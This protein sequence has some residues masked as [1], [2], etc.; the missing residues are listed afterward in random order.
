M[1][2]IFDIE[3]DGLDATKIHCIAVRN[4]ETG[5]S[6]VFSPENLTEGFRLLRCAKNLIGHNIISY[7]LPVIEKLHSMI[8]PAAE[9][10]DTLLLARLC[11]PDV[12]QDDWSRVNDGFPKELVGRHSL[13]AWGYRL[14]I[15]KDD[16][17]E[18]TDWAEYSEEM[19]AYC[20]RDTEVTAALWRA[21]RGEKPTKTA[22]QIEH[23]F[24]KVIRQMEEAGFGFDRKAAEELAQTLTVRREE[25]RSE[26]VAAFPPTIV[27]MKIKTKEI[28]FNPASRMDIARGLKKLH[29]WEP[30]DF[31]PDGRAKIDESVLSSMDYT[32]AKLLLE[33]LMVSKRLG[34][35]AE[36]KE[37][38]LGLEKHGRIHGRVNTNGAVT[39]RC[40]HSK[41]NMAQVPGGRSPYG[42]ECRSLFIP[43]PGWVLVGADA[44]GLELRCLAHYMA[45]YDGG[46]YAK[47]ILE[48]DI[49]TTNQ[50]AAGLDTRDQAKLFIYAFLYGAGDEKVGT[51]IGG[52]SKEGK[53][54]KKQFLER[55]PALKI[56][57]EKVQKAAKERGF[58]VGLDG[59]K[60]PVRSAH[61]ALNTL[62]QSAGAVI[63]KQATII[64][65][66]ELE[67]ANIAWG[68]DW[69][70]VA[71][72][73]DEVQ[74]ECDG[75]VA[76]EVGVTA[77]G[78]IREAGE[79]LG[80]KCRLDGEWRSG[81]SWAETH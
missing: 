60:L 28:P 70:L 58:L 11:W 63:M 1:N 76:S 17:G 68:R 55:T 8:F 27:E 73:H 18:T 42:K 20:L 72:V 62:L 40:T 80:F 14:G 74:I 64:L 66:R 43:K 59:R 81:R 19:A 56:L 21:I 15:R 41:P 24:A 44:S 33:Y 3:T 25:L 47:E 79:S 37:A 22:V 10:Y 51:I 38:W 46:A 35:L 48:G 75:G 32:E 9:V 67:S 53:R 54:L 36:G 2:L 12:Q 30:Q 31:T 7:D 13:K 45:P 6:R 78:S 5:E 71:H 77:V 50:N 69:R 34:Q 16:W 39:G 65:Y 29:G 57:R 23:G 61:S 4:A 52:G 26:L 49:H